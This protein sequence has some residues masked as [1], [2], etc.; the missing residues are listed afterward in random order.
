MAE[1]DILTSRP[2]TLGDD[3]LELAVFLSELLDLVSE[4]VIILPLLDLAQELL[5]ELGFVHLLRDFEVDFGAGLLL[6]NA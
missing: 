1:G 3:L 5:D 6:L 2:L 4:L